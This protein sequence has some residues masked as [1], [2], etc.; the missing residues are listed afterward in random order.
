MVVGA[1]SASAAPAIPRRVRRAA[2]PALPYCAAH[3]A[4]PFPSTSVQG[5][6]PSS[7]SATVESVGI[8]TASESS[9]PVLLRAQSVMTFSQSRR[10]YEHVVDGLS[11]SEVFLLPR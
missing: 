8:S 11:H 1:R 9:E 2:A 7:S 10:S 6:R 5:G 3:D 4:G